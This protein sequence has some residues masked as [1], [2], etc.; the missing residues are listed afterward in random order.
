MNYNKEKDEYLK[1]VKIQDELKKIKHYRWGRKQDNSWD[2]KTRFVYKIN[3][4]KELMSECKKNFNDDEALTNYAVCRFY[5]FHSHNM[6]QDIFM[7]S[8]KVTAEKNPKHKTK[9]F[10]INNEPFDLKLSVYPKSLRGKLKSDK[11]I[12]K[13]MYKNQSNGHRHHLKNRIFVIVLDDNNH[14]ESWKVKRNFSLIKHEVDNFLQN[15]EFV[16][17]DGVKT[18]VIRVIT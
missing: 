3:T 12:S 2:H 14:D 1:N 5:N 10:Y 17:I 6:V 13:W 7:S 4:Y 9:D 15:P 8:D 16:E 18:A 11:D